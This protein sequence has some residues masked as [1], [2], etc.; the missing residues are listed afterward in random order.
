M[1][2]SNEND[3][4]VAT[5]DTAR[6]LLKSFGFDAQR[7]NVRSAVTLLALAGL[8]PGDHW[9]DSTTPR[10]GVQKIMDWSGAH[11]AK[12]YATG[13]REDF[14]KK[15][16]RQWV[17]NGFAVLNPDNLNIATNSQL[18]EYCLSDEAVR[19]VRACGTDAFEDSLANFLN[20]ASE[21]V[22]ARAEALHTA[23]ISVD[24]PDGGEF[25]LSPAGQN[26]LLKKMVE[27][28]MPRFAPGAKVLYLGDTRGKHTL[29][30]ERIFEEALGLTFDP[31]GRMPDL[32]LHDESR[33]WLFLMEAVK[34]KGPFDDER[35][36]TMRE[37]FATPAAGLVFINCFENREAMRQWLPE[38]A[39]ETEAWVADDPDHLIHLN[40]SRFLGPYER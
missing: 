13:S 22:K 31:H 18:N 24:L 39:W 14:R 8:K 20:V 35:H 36:R 11:W 34:S 1:T 30:E 37:L 21:A 33:K 25:L 26:P 28:F 5:I 15:T 9:A 32:V 19:A 29:F 12:P 10:L 16:L 2:T 4:T 3:E 40:G 6:A 23:M 27:D 7:H 17:D 38:L